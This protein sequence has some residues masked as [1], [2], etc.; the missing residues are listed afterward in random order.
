MAEARFKRCEMPCNPIETHEPL[1]SEAPLWFEGCFHI[2]IS[3][4]VILGFRLTAWGTKLKNNLSMGI[5]ELKGCQQ[6]F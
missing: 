6:W 1:S 4:E 2:V 5:F 3:Q